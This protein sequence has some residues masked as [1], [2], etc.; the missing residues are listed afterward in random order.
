MALDTKSLA[1]GTLSNSQAELYK[2]PSG[3]RAAVNQVFLHNTNST[4]ET[5][6]LYIKRG[7]GTVRKFR[8][9][10]LGA[11]E[12]GKIDTTIMLS[13]EDSI[14]GDT[15]SSCNYVIAGGEG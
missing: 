11:D 10:I 1:D 8:Q 4:S 13:S 2:V 5:V 14:L 6:S 12:S 15:T 7:A 9:F 3:S